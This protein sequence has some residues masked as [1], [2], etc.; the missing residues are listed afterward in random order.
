MRIEVFS[1]CV[2]PWCYIG[3]RHLEQALAQAD[4]GPADIH[5]RAFQLN[6]DLPPEGRDRHTYL[7]AKFGGPDAVRAIHAR[8]EEAG[9]GAGIEFQFDKIARSPNTLNAHRLIR[10]ADTQQRAADLVETLFRGYFVE[11]RDL[12]DTNTLVELARASGLTGDLRA[13]LA[14]NEQRAEVLEDLH[15]AHRLG[16]GGVPFFILDGRYALSGAQ[17]VAVFIQALQAARQKSRAVH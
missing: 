10:L 12:G 15:T 2:C 7:D 13:W 5:W 9:R 1:D 8:I 3:K 6:P 4:L 11:G 16:I 17:P 14:G